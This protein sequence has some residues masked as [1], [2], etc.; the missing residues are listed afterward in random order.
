MDIVSAYPA[1]FRKEPLWWLSYTDSSK[2]AGK[3]FL[4]VNIIQAGD[5]AVAITKSWLL[6]I[7]P[8]GAIKFMGPLEAEWIAPEWRDRLLT[9]DEAMSVPD[10]F[11][12]EIGGDDGK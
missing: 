11:R 7:N 12:T 6:N 3:Q 8:G 2:P 4:G 5:I 1:I 9:R 10:P